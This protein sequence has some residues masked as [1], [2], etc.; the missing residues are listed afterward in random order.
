MDWDILNPDSILQALS[1]SI[2]D[3][4][5]LHLSLNA[6]LRL[7]KRF[8]FELC[9]LKL[10]GFQEALVEAWKCGS[11]IVDP[12]NRLDALFRNAAVFLQ[13]WGQRKIGNTKLQIAMAHMLILKLDVAQER[14]LLTPGER[15]LRRTW[16]QSV[17]GLASLERTI[18]RQRSRLRWI[19]EGDANTR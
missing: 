8:Q 2:L 1:S 4:A 3:H 19:K 11:R 18:V 9:W 12:F 5:P 17:L 13:S 10:D 7:K 16:K 15:W 14:R 6:A